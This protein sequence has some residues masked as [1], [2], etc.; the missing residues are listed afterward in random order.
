MKKLIIIAFIFSCA[1]VYSQD[2]VLP[3]NVESAFK[4][5]Y[6][7]SRLDG[8]RFEKELY[9]IDFIT[10][11]IS[12][13]SVFNEQGEWLETSEAISD[14]DIPQ[15]LKDYIKHNYPQGIISYSEKVVTLDSPGF[16]RT[17]IVN[18]MKF[19]VIQ[20]DNNGSNIK[21]TKVEDE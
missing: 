4:N 13:T 19:I 16:I 11:S 21:V 1:S 20:C 6:P 10:K 5:K 3:Q 17:N 12:Y 18:D 7:T 2:E 14:F 15:A 8:W 9:Y